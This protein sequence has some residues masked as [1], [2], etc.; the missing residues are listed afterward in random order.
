MFLVATAFP[1]S[2]L[3]LSSTVN[4]LFAPGSMKRARYIEIGWT[5]DN[6]ASVISLGRPLVM[7]TSVTAINLDSWPGGLSAVDGCSRK[8][9]ATVVALS[10][11]RAHFTPGRLQSTYT[12]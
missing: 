6:T 8:V 2:R 12:A 3:S 7:H 4:H 11:Y 5:M 9:R 1:Q 10:N